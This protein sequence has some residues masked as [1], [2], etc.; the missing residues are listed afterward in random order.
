LSTSGSKGRRR[1][2]PGERRR[3]RRKARGAQLAIRGEVAWLYPKKD[4]PTF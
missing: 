2:V 4:K 1:L 3:G